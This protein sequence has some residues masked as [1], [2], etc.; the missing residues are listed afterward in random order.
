MNW[1]LWVIIGLVAIE[2]VCRTIDYFE[3]KKLNKEK[4]HE[5]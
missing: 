1:I 5:Q 4:K 2:C 3:Q